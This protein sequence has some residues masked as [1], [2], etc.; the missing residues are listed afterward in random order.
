MAA[1]LIVISAVLFVLV[2]AGD[3]GVLITRALMLVGFG[4]IGLQLLRESDSDWEHQ[5][6]L[7][8]LR[9]AAGAT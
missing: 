5:P 3:T 1:P 7:R 6:E 2:G 8:G 9:A 4:S